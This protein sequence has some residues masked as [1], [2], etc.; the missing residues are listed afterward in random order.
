MGD[1]MAGQMGHLLENPGVKAKMARATCTLPCP[2]QVYLVSDA[3]WAATEVL[4]QSVP[5]WLTGW[6]PL[7]LVRQ[8]WNF[9]VV[10]GLNDQYP[11]A[12]PLISQYPCEWFCLTGLILKTVTDSSFC[13]SF[14]W[15]TCSLLSNTWPLLVSSS[16]VPTWKFILLGRVELLKA[17]PPLHLSWKLVTGSLG[18]N[19]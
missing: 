10:Q 2:G 13:C 9:N 16:P 17:H 18:F 11:T 14:T 1:T 4:K 3:C 15:V 7:G 6:F 19:I 5:V 12:V 8:P